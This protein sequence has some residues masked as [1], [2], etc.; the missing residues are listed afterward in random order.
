MLSKIINTVN[1]LILMIKHWSAFISLGK[2]MSLILQII[3]CTWG[4]G[5]LLGFLRGRLISHLHFSVALISSYDLGFQFLRHLFHT[6]LSLM[7]VLQSPLILKRMM[8]E[9]SKGMSI[10]LICCIFYE[11]YTLYTLSLGRTTTW[12]RSLVLGISHYRNNSV[13]SWGEQTPLTHPLDVS[14]KLTYRHLPAS[15]FFLRT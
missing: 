4:E 6:T 12:A 13:K 5:V 3:S 10:F 11:Q 2:L 8:I 15:K 14:L 9:I 1:F 7:L